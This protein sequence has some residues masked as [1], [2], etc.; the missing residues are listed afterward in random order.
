VTKLQKWSQHKNP[1]WGE[2]EASAMPEP[3]NIK[4]LV[5]DDN[6]DVR[7]VTCATLEEGGFKV[8][9]ASGVN[10]ALKLLAAQAFDI[11]VTDLNM[12]LVGDGLTVVS[13]MRHFNPQAITLILSGFPEMEKAAAAILAQADAI[14]VKPAGLTGLVRTIRER[15]NRS[16]APTRV[17]SSIAT[18]LEEETR[19]T[20]HDWLSRVHSTAHI[21]AIKMDDEKRSAHLPQLFRD[22]IT[23]LR[24]PLHLGPQ[25]LVS[26]TAATHGLLRRQQG[27]SAAMMVE[28][29]RML[30]VSIFQTLQSNLFRVNFSKVLESVMAIADEVDSQLA[31]AMTGYVSESKVD[32][33]PTVA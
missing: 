28:E 25:A 27:Y 4:I 16:A 18:I 2:L 7:E 14:L 22:L 6:D 8:T 31:Q 32:A 5:V 13:A 19:S 3:A 21:V 26:P 10:E 9:C 15:L 23:R 1:Q 30:Q 17:I 11:L 20:I 33:L 12:P 29:S 24:S